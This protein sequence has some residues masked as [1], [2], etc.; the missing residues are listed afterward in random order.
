MAQF[1]AFAPEVEVNGETVL[2]IVKAFPEFMQ[3][4]AIKILSENG[5]HNPRADKWYSQQAW[6][7]AFKQISERYGAHTLYR[8]GKAIPENA[9]FPT[10]IDSIEKAL[11][12]ID[13]A[14][15][16]NH[17]NGD[18]GFYKVVS[19]DST[20]RKIVMHCKNPY[21]CDFD[22]GIIT[23]MARKFNPDAT[24]ELDTHKP[25]RKDGAND[26]WYIISYGL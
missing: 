23:A 22:K 21:P 3:I 8:I 4:Y 18:I 19:H 13:I 16:M 5:I 14:Y 26:S 24:V 25:S 2:T 6:L 15:N 11:A 10:E 12:S 1:E 9:Q 17:R 7:K 20:E